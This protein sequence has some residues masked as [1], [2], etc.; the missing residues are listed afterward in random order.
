MH[1]KEKLKKLIEN[2]SEQDKARLAVEIANSQLSSNA[3]LTA[4]IAVL[5]FWT[6][7]VTLFSREIHDF[8]VSFGIFS[9]ILAPILIVIVL[10]ISF[11]GAKQYFCAIFSRHET[12][13]NEAYDNCFWK[14][15]NGDI[16]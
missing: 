9:I 11:I 1:S 4:W 12:S 16:C 5:A 6:V 7:I 15:Q 10:V 8:L 13:I 14:E 2:P 3:I